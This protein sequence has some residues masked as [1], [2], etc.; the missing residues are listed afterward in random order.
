MF[1][2]Q[3]DELTNFYKSK[4]EWKC[5]FLKHIW[6]D[7]RNKNIPDALPIAR[8][9]GQL[10]CI[11]LN[12]CPTR[13]RVL[14]R[15]TQEWNCCVHACSVVHAPSVVHASG[16]V[17]EGGCTSLASHGEALV[18]ADLCWSDDIKLQWREKHGV[19]MQSQKLCKGRAES[20]GHSNSF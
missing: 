18:P 11:T 2:F 8:W 9:S 14:I 16:L 4:S 17:T 19:L 1:V 13:D 5:S 7:S 10:R 20:M 6:F 15:F 12:S 3:S